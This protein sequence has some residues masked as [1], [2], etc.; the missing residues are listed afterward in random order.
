MA[1]TYNLNMLGATAKIMAFLGLQLMNEVQGC[2][3]KRMEIWSINV[4]F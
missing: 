3:I 1:N 4:N 2:I